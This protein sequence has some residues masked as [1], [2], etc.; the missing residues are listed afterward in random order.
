VPPLA[1]T[2][3]K[4]AKQLLGLLDC[5]VGKTRAAS[6]KKVAKGL[7]IST[8]PGSGKTLPAGT[9]VTLTVSSGRPK[10]KHSRR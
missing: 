6:S 9:K 5:R 1:G 8:T 4:L 7:V 3:A 10:R 2:T